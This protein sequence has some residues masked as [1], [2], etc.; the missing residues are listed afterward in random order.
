MHV[1][2]KAKF[3]GCFGLWF[4]FGDV[5]G[6]RGVGFLL[7]FGVELIDLY[8]ARLVVSGK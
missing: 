8:L 6:N 7:R 2:S 3:N 1:C 4:A 5:F